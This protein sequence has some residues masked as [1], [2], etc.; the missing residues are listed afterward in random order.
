M[1]KKY[2]NETAD[3]GV[4]KILAEDCVLRQSFDNLSISW[5]G[6][7]CVVIQKEKATEPGKTPD[8]LIATG[9]KSSA[10]SLEGR[11]DA[12]KRQGWR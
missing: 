4:K 1:E 12:Q 8:D 2:K 3:K 11:S 9:R 10:I 7:M 6:R 5:C